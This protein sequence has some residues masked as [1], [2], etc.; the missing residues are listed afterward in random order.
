MAL[1]DQLAKGTAK[2][3]LGKIADLLERNNIDIEDVGAV[4][5]INVWQ[6]FYKD[7]AGEAHT[8][9]M[10]GITLS[11]KWAE[12]PAW[13]V[14]QPGPAVRVNKPTKRKTSTS[15]WKTAVVLPDIQFGFY[16]D[17]RDRLHP[18]HDEAALAVALQVVR[19]VR[20]DRV[21]MVGDNADFPELSKYRLSPAF[22]RTT[23]ATIDR[24]T[25]FCGELRDAAPEAEADWIAG[26][27]E[28]RL[29]NYILDNAKAAFGLKKGNAPDSW[30]VLSV[31]ELCRFD[32]FQIRFHPG[33][34]ANEVW[35]NDRLRVIHGNKVNSNGS[36]AIKYLDSERVSTIYGHVHRRE[37]NE[38]TRHT[39]RG[40]R[41]IMAASPG[42]LCRID[43]KVPSTNGGTDLD[44]V[45]MANSENWQQGVAV[46]HYQPGDKPFVYEQV[47]IHDGW[48]MYQGKEYAA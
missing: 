15:S 31:P 11:P 29:P 12:G 25:T 1:A 5:K 41:T 8:V 32:E 36:T 19:D 7:A 33:Y 44:G 20:P 18:T 46:V 40:P 26:N 24:M 42:C 43:G 9:D 38:R 47:A 30:P 48:A 2:D 23:Q 39:R 27:H 28:E 37:W 45:P 4:Q 22:Q 14:I 13:P 17:T 10:S 3:R 16:R 35:V 34:P 6:G 21:V